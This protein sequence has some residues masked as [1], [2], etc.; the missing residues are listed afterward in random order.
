MKMPEAIEKVVRRGNIRFMHEKSQF[1]VE[2]FTFIK[3]LVVC[4]Q[5]TINQCILEQKVVSILPV[6]YTIAIQS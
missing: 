1:S 6:E 3:K 5:F 4:N 2:Y